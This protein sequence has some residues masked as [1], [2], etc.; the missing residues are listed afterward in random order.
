[1]SKKEQPAVSV[2]VPVYNVE[3]YLRECLDSIVAQTLTDL[4]ILLINDGSTDGSLEILKEYAKKDGRIKV[5]DKPNEGYGKT[6]NRGIEMATGEYI[7]IV[8]SDDWIEPDMY[9]TLYS[10]AKTHN[11][12]VAKSSFVAFDDETGL[13]KRGPKMPKRDMEEVINPRQNPGIFCVM[14]CI[15]SAIYRRDFLNNYKIRF[16]ESPGASYQD[17]SFNFKVWVM[18]PR[19]YLTGKTLVHYRKHTEQSV[20]SKEKV[21]CVCDE[22]EEIERYMA[23]YSVLFEKLKRIF[24]RIKYGSYIWNFKRLDAE[25]K[26]AFRKRMQEELIPALQNKTIDLSGMDCRDRWRILNIIHPPSPWK[27]VRSV[28][29]SL[30]RCLI[31]NR[32]RNGVMEIQILFGLIT[33]GKNV[34]VDQEGERN[35]NID[36]IPLM[37]QESHKQAKRRVA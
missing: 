27:T 18:A 8:E 17:T 25:N 13:N 15:W 16:L 37:L 1:M 31:K 14:P 5:I 2:I 6:M 12:E 19:I 11:V 28:W 9:E 36:V 21:F 26:E 34:L 10:I 33:V 20:K 23:S 35:R 32:Q 29:A 7:G 3:K 24:N 30:K 22:Y 4:E